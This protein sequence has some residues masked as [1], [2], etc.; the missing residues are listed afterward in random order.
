MS[1]IMTPGK[2]LW[3]FM[4]RS[5]T[6]NA[7]SPCT[8][9]SGVIS[10]ANTVPWVAN[11][12]A[13]HTQQ[14]FSSLLNIMVRT[15]VLTFQLFKITSTYNNIIYFLNNKVWP[16]LTNP[17]ITRITVNVK[18]KWTFLEAAKHLLNNNQQKNNNNNNNS[19]KKIKDQSTKIKW[20]K[21]W[22]LLYRQNF[23]NS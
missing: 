5:G 4:S 15:S 21:I 19:T 16:I 8:L 12:P 11:W 17:P 23:A 14:L 10:W 13:Q 22:Q 3:V 7:C 9:P 18:N 20:D 2:G 6:T 1:P